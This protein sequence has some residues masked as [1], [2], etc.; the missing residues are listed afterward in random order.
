MEKK[1]DVK[2]KELEFA[3]YGYWVWGVGCKVM[4]DECRVLG[5][6]SLAFSLFALL[7]LSPYVFCPSGFRFWMIVFRTLCIKVRDSRR[8]R[9]WVGMGV[10]T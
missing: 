2:R 1:P 6:E 4:S 8:G 5:G 10:S 3:S 7:P 9:P